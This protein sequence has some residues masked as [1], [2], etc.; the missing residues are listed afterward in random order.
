MTSMSVDS[1]E[2]NRLTADLRTTPVKAVR[3]VQAVIAKGAADIAAEAQRLAPVDTGMLRS[4]IG[5]DLLSGGLTAV[6]GPTVSY[7]AFVEFGT[8]RQA[9][10]AYMGP[11]LDRVGPGL[12]V[13]L[14]L[15]SGE[16]G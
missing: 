15:A 11:A 14:A 3:R 2:L 7:G 1:S 5:Y 9:P 6:V 10:A 12:M 13:A 16:L 8:R 4:S